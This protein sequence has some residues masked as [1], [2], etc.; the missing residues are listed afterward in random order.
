VVVLIADDLDHD[1][2]CAWFGVNP[3]AY[4]EREGTSFKLRL[5][6]NPLLGSV[7]IKCF[8]FSNWR[9]WTSR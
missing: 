3:M 1:R 7:Y 2:T 4:E 9:G 5:D 8:S 6:H